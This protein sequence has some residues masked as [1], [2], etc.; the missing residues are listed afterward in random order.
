MLPL[1]SRKPCLRGRI[2]SCAEH[3]SAAEKRQRGCRTPKAEH[4]SATK[5]GGMAPTFHTS[6]CSPVSALSD[7]GLGCSF[8]KNRFSGRWGLRP[9][10]PSTKTLSRN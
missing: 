3:G 5:S 1:S 9:H 8:M 10:A 6:L 2:T 4:G 7:V